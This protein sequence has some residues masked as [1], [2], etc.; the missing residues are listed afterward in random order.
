MKIIIQTLILLV[1]LTGVKGQGC[2]VNSLVGKWKGM[3]ADTISNFN[4]EI[5]FNPDLTYEKSENGIKTSGKYKLS[6]KMLKLYACA[7]GE[8][9]KPYFGRLIVFGS[10]SKKMFHNDCN[11][12]IKLPVKF[13]SLSNGKEEVRYRYICFTKI[14]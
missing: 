14:N 10:I 5:I 4:Y 2:P 12:Q 13:I 3:P 6:R 11:C 1:V 8:T 9:C 7:K